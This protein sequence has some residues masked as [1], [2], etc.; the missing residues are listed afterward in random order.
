MVETTDWRTSGNRYPNNIQFCA[1]IF[2]ETD[3][4]IFFIDDC[5]DFTPSDIA[6]IF[7]KGLEILNIKSLHAIIGGSL[8]GGIGWEMLVKKSKPCR[9]FHPVSLRF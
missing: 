9:N 1:S 2:P 3:L 4:M 5:E 8:G 7:L 6:N